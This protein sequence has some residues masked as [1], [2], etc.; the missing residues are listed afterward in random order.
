MSGTILRRRDRTARPPR[1]EHYSSA[2]NNMAFNSL[3]AQREACEAY[4]ASQKPEGWVLLEGHYEDG[5]FSAKDLERPD[6]QRLIADIEAGEVDVVVVYKIDRLVRSLMDFAK[7]VELFEAHDVTFVSITQSF[8]TTTSMGRLT[9]NILLSFAQFER[10]VTGERIR[11]K[12]AASRKKGMWMGGTPP[13]GYDVKERK[14]VVNKTE[15]TLVRAI[16]ERF[17]KTGSATVLVKELVAEGH[18]TKTWITAAGKERPGRS[19]DKGH[20]YRLLNNRV[21]LGEAVHRGTAYPGEHKAIVPRAMWDKAH[22]ILAQNARSRGNRTRARTPALLKGL[23]RCTACNAAM[24]PTHTNSRGRRY[25]YYV[26]VKSI[27][28]GAAACEIGSIAAA[29]IEGVVT[30]QVR[31]LLQTPEIAARTIAACN[32]TDG[33]EPA[34]NE[35]EVVEALGRLDEVW[36]ELFPAEQARIVALLVDCIEVASDGIDIHL[37]LAGIHSLAGELMPEAPDTGASNLEAAA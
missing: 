15:A 21:Y 30:G 4:V 8:N 22:A 23:L 1:V 27:K 7:L 28:N 31:R 33:D 10:E 32:E 3:D 9:L 26:C 25:R 19:I 17:T 18:R 36:D 13:L 34:V 16:F 12:I 11:D 14:L 37:R 2:V 5:G 24:T 6:L 35:R 20:L 29:E